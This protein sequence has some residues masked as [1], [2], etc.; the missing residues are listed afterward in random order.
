V[1][2]VRPPP[3]T[4]RAAARAPRPRPY[5]KGA[6]KDGW[7][8]AFGITCLV[9]GIGCHVAFAQ[10]SAECLSG[11]GQ[12]GQA[13]SV[14]AQRSCSVAT[15]L[16]G[17]TGWGI[18]VGL[19]LIVLCGLSL[20]GV[21]RNA[22]ASNALRAAAVQAKDDVSAHPSPPAAWPGPSS[23]VPQALAERPAV[24]APPPPPLGSS[25]TGA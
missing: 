19:I 24:W 7:G 22:S 15:T 2:E 25:A 10:K 11:F 17:W 4:P 18:T 9:T 23:Q 1:R 3:G 8:L 5:R 16:E 20:T 14:T 12:L 13:F 21:F 6:V